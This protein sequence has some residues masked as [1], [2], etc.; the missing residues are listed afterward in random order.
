MLAPSSEGNASGAGAPHPRPLGEGGVRG[1]VVIILTLSPVALYLVA[2]WLTVLALPPTLQGA[3]RK[4]IIGGAQSL[5]PA[6][7]KFSAQFRKKH[8]GVEIDFRRS[9]SNYAINAAQSG[10]IHIGLVTRALSAAEESQ[11]HTEIVGR[12]AI[13]LLTYPWNSVTDL[14]LEQLRAIYLG[15]I[16]NWKEVGGNDTGIVP[17][18]R[19]S[20]SALH[21]IFVDRLFG[22]SFN[23]RERAFVLRANKDK[24]LRTI[25][26]I[27]GALGYGIV[28][29]EE[30]QAEGVKVLAV[31]K[32][33]PTG[34]NIQQGIYP[35]TRPQ[36]LISKGQPD[37]VIREWMLGFAQFAREGAEAANR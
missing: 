14:S 35:F 17:L 36:L 29:V 32:T 2:L 8:P 15:K 18:T 23:G 13:I 31:N 20:S 22:K 11:F 30:A 37:R 3:E 6:A 19:E 33:P 24:V 25:K 27:R 34:P 10:E 7:E 9:N 21:A 16:T 1:T 5:T 28:R 12:D 26:R 4:I